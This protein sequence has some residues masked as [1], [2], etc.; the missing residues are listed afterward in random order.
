MITV[1]LNNLLVYYGLGLIAW[2]FVC[3]VIPFEWHFR[4]FCLALLYN[5]VPLFFCTFA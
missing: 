2:M 5:A 3:E 1:T 4:A